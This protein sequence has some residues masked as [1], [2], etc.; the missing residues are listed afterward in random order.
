[1]ASKLPIGQEKYVT[2]IERVSLVKFIIASK[3]IYPLT[4]LS[5]PLGILKAISKLECAYIWTVTDKVSSAK[6]KVKWD[7]VCAPKNMG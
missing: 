5:L 1:M 6:C 2:T 4:V 7:V 3:S